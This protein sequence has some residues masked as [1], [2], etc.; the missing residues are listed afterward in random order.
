MTG[1]AILPDVVRGTAVPAATRAQGPPAFPADDVLDDAGGMSYSNGALQL[2][3]SSSNALDGNTAGGPGVDMLRIQKTASQILLPL[4][5]LAAAALVL[6]SGCARLGRRVTFPYYGASP[7]D[8]S[9]VDASSLE[10]KRIVI[11]PGHGGVFTG[12]LGTGGLEED[13]VNLGVALYLWGLLADAGAEVLL[14]RTSDRDFV[15]GSSQDLRGD[16]ASRVDVASSFNADLF[17]SLHHN[18]DLSRS[19]VKNQVETYFKMLDDG[20]SRDAA[21]A[22]H[23]HLKEMLRISVGDVVPGN[24]HVLRNAPCPAVLGEPSYITN[25]WVEQ[26]LVLA[27]K[28][29][30]EAQAYFLGIVEYFSKGP[31]DIAWMAPEDTTLAEPPAEL[32]AGLAEDVT[33]VWPSSVVCELDGQEIPAEWDTDRRE[34]VSRLSRPLASGAHHF[35]FSFRNAGGNSSGR[36]C[37]GFALDLE[38]AAI[39]AD[40]RPGFLPEKGGVIVRAELADENGNS[41]GDGKAVLFSSKNGTFFPDS[42]TTLGGIASSVFLPDRTLESASF[43]ASSGSLAETLTVLRSAGATRCFLVTDAASET[44]LAGARFYS[45]DSLVSTATPQGLAVLDQAEGKVIVLLEGYTPAPLPPLEFGGQ[46]GQEVTPRPVETLKMRPVALGVFRGAKVTLD[47]GSQGVSQPEKAGRR[48]KRP[49]KHVAPSVTLPADWSAKV[50]GHLA[51]LLRGA[52]AEVLVLSREM[53]DAERVLRSELFG[54]TRY[55]RV[56][57]THENSASVL[58]YPGSSSGARTAR[59]LAQWCGRQSARSQPGLREDAHYVLRQ[60]SVPSV[61]LSVPADGARGAWAEPRAVAY[62]AY[63]ALSEDLGLGPEI[64]TKFTLSASGFTREERPFVELDGFVVLPLSADGSATFFCE[65][66]QHLVRVV[67]ERRSTEPRFVRVEA[68]ARGKAATVR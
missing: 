21:L 38:P 30:L 10:G 36:H 46:A 50:T 47:P 28:Q 57:T 62:A 58:Y 4:A 9:G 8:L 64:L 19:Q 22:I 40:T 60:T 26:K 34:L 39:S 24:Y 37:A 54:A 48:P 61:I 65:E 7:A 43:F 45:G 12:A 17:V 67:S 63:L 1:Q 31:A 18:S 15:S 27:E 32:R 25:P 66:G 44:P 41:I 16:L 23:R 20:P 56:Q 11:D 5:V 35:C 68:S 13:D 49:A 2:R 55:V 42:V 51:T 33:G 14:T 6:S 29:L 52:G 53:P 59:L 3:F